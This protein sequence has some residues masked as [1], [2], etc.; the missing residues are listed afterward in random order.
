MPK[1]FV[2]MGGYHENRDISDI[3]KYFEKTSWIWKMVVVNSEVS[4]FKK[5][6]K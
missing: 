3:L 5:N 2:E 4:V 6:L 1:K